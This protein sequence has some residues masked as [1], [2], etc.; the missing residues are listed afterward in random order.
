[1]EDHKQS[2]PEPLL[3]EALSLQIFEHDMPWRIN[4]VANTVPDAYSLRQ[5]MVKPK[6]YEARLSLQLGEA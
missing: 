2:W 5:T 6:P 4:I 3:K 1:M